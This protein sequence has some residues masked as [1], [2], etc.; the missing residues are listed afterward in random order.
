[1]D[2]D[3]PG[4]LVLLRHGESTGNAVG[5]FTGLLDV[6]LTEHG[7]HEAENAGRLLAA[8]EAVPTTIHTSLLTRA[9]TTAAVVAVVVGLPPGMVHHDARLNERDYGALTGRT[10]SAVLAEAGRERFTRWRRSVDTAPPSM[11]AEQ[12]QRLGGVAPLADRPAQ[13]AART[14]SLRDVIGRVTAF[15]HEVVARELAQGAT[16]LVVA[17]GNSLRAYCAV[18]DHLDDAEVEA[19]NIPTGQP[20]VRTFATDLRALPGGRY[21]DEDAARAAAREVAEQGVSG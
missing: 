18:L 8:A 7:E 17:H 3:G 1:M 20:L 6:P 9:I 15:H 5:M 21:L 10:K 14:E 13:D 11:S 16:V 4:R 2:D 19:L 12:E